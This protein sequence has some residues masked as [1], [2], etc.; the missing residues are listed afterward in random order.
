M[1]KKDRG[2]VDSPT[3]PGDG[4]RMKTKEY[5]RELKKLHAG[6]AAVHRPFRPRSRAI[7]PHDPGRPLRTVSLRPG[8]TYQ[9]END[10]LW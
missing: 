1:A 3:L 4:A 5:E 7:R 9:P 6:S 8:P 10:P 2:Q